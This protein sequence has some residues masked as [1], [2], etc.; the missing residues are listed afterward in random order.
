MPNSPATV[1]FDLRG[2][3]TLHKIQIGNNPRAKSEKALRPACV[4]PI[5]AWTSLER[6]VPSVAPMILV[7]KK[8]TGVHWKSNVKNQ[9]IPK[10]TMMPTMNMI[11]QRWMLEYSF[12]CEDSSWILTRAHSWRPILMR[13]K[14]METE[15]NSSMMS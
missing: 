14:V 1:N 6:Q 13:R 2:I 4:Y 5:P 8:L 9:G 15:K 12:R 10:I 11:V 3:F 7:Q